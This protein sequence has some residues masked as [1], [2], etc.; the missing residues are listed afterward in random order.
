MAIG[1]PGG[2]N[3]RQ[4]DNSM[5]KDLGYLE[6]EITVEKKMKKRLKVE[7]YT[8]VRLLLRSNLYGGKVIKR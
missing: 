8:R 3:V 1:L 7:C 4:I 5:Y 2:E 6:I